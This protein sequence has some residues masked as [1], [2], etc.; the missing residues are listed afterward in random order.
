MNNEPN[1][2]ATTTTTSLKTNWL[3]FTKSVTFLVLFFP[4]PNTQQ[5]KKK[6]SPEGHFQESHSLMFTHPTPQFTQF[7]AI[8]SSPTKR[9]FQSFPLKSLFLDVSSTA[10]I[11]SFISNGSDHPNIP[12][13]GTRSRP[14]DL[15]AYIN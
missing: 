4:G 2:N 8:S 15:G 14:R 3:Y 11:H 7:P 5:E 9:T 10:S 1:Q 13:A 6:H 12:A